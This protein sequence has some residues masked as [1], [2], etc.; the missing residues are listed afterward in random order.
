MKKNLLIVLFVGLVS[1]ISIDIVSAKVATVDDLIQTNSNEAV[2]ISEYVKTEDGFKVVSILP[3]SIYET[4]FKV[5]NNIITY[6]D[7]RDYTN[8]SDEEKFN[9]IFNDYTYCHGVISTLLHFYGLD[10]DN[11]IEEQKFGITFEDGSPISYTDAGGSIVSTK[12]IKSFSIDLVK[13]DQT[14]TEIINTQSN[15]ITETEKII[16]E[17]EIV[18]NIKTTEETIVEEAEEVNP[19]T[20][21]NVKYVII[22]LGLVLGGITLCGYKLKKKYN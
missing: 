10:D 1:I 12:S 3:E 6:V 9:L 13:F 22:S 16:T 21:D 18:D 8:I 4:N 2:I 5:E 7:N 20:G 14:V 11:D 15:T 17:N 19:N